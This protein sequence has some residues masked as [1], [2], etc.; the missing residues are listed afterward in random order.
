[1]IMFYLVRKSVLGSQDEFEDLDFEVDELSLGS[2]THNTVV[3]DDLPIGVLSLR[4]ARGGKVRFNCSEQLS[5]KENNHELTSG[6]LK[7]GKT[8]RFGHFDIEIIKCPAGFDCAIG[9]TQSS[10]KAKGAQDRYQ[11]KG[12]KSRIN[13]RSLSYLSF[14]G[15][16]VFFLILPIYAPIDWF[17]HKIIS[18]NSWSSGSL[19]M[20]HRIPEI[21]DDCKTCHVKPF[22]KVADEQCLACHRNL[23]DHVANNHPAVDELERFICEN[24][25]KEHNEPARLTR[26]D[27]AL[28]IDCHQK[29]KQ[30]SD[31]SNNRDTKDVTGFDVDTHPQFKLSLIQSYLH[32]G[33]YQWRTVR[34]R[35]VADKLVEENSNLKFSHKIHLDGDLVQHELSGESLNCDSCHQLKN[36]GEH[37][38]PI[39]MDK[40]C[41]S[42]HQLNFDAFNPDLE[43]PHGDLKAAMVMLQAHY[44]REFTDPN[45]RSKRSRKKIRRIPGKHSNNASCEGT[46]LDCGRREAL[47]EAEFQFNNSGCITCHEVRENDSNELLDKWLVKPIKINDDWY[48]KARFDHNS[49]FSVKKYDRQEICLTCHDVQF[50]DDSKDIAMPKQKICLECH[51]QGQKNNVELKCI[52]CHV[53][54]FTELREDI[55]NHV[56]E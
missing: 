19:A 50:S 27:D 15:I 47:T 10:R 4:L 51:Q 45:L 42:C 30:L 22:E 37:Y 43:L 35:S 28:C 29:I 23:A 31:V 17:T 14:I 13:L 41:R 3:L 39:S 20:A 26:T 21:G 11:I 34:L 55:N 46:G 7:A 49:H 33:V 38:Q 32:N 5:L 54:H 18:D 53:F 1:M 16:I 12:S 36:D 52:A 25:H 44:I 56:V 8:Y 9:I 40:D 6:V 24:C 2:E 48:S